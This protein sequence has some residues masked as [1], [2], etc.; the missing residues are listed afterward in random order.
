MSSAFGG[1]AAAGGPSG[2]EDPAEVAEAVPSRPPTTGAD[3]MML[4]SNLI[5]YAARHNDDTAGMDRVW[6]D[7]FAPGAQNRHRTTVRRR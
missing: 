7:S 2:F 4:D 5:I 1:I 6:A 3:R